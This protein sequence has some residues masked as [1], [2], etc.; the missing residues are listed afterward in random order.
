MIVRYTIMENTVFKN[1]PKCHIFNFP[2]KKNY[3]LQNLFCPFQIF[4]NLCNCFILPSNLRYKNSFEDQKRFL[5]SEK[6]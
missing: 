5:K 2:T 6:G 3:A 1:L 4:S